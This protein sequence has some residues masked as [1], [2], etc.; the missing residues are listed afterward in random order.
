MGVYVLGKR[1][2]MEALTGEALESM[3]DRLDSD[4]VVDEEAARRVWEHLL[5]DDGLRNLMMGRMTEDMKER[6]SGVEMVGEI[7]GQSALESIPVWEGHED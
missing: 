2:C 4:G 3:V 7:R 1:S 6:M 5:E